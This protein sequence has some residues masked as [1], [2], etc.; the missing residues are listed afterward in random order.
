MAGIKYQVESKGQDFE[1]EIIN[2]FLRMIF[3]ENL[4]QKNYFL[5]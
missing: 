5:G 4:V 3:Q 2:N 1:Y